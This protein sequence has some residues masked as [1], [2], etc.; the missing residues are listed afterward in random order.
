MY[1]LHL[2]RCGGVMTRKRLIVPACLWGLV[3]A[4]VLCAFLFI[5]AGATPNIQPAA[6]ELRMWDMSLN[7]C[8]WSFH[9]Y[10]NETVQVEF[11]NLADRGYQFDM[12]DGTT[13]W[14]DAGESVQHEYAIYLDSD[15][16][17]V[18]ITRLSDGFEMNALMLKFMRV[19]Q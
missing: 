13:L 11:A 15:V 7:P 17:R 12:G 8:K 4:L 19:D 10:G 14:L 2:P 6:G 18:P 16:V 3:T 1:D 9:E 5:G